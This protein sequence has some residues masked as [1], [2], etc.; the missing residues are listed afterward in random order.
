MEL[1]GFGGEI[2][3]KGVSAKLPPVPV[4]AVQPIPILGPDGGQFVIGRC[5]GMGV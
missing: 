5:W 1:P 2:A 4:G 3:E